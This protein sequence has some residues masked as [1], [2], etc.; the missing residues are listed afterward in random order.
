MSRV[1]SS[2]RSRF[3]RVAAA[4]R[5][6]II[7]LTALLLVAMVGM[8]AFAVDIGYINLTRVEL[9]TCVDAAALAGAY[10]LVDGQAAAQSSAQDF[11]SRNKVRNRTLTLAN[12]TIETGNW[13][14]SS[15]QF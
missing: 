6:N 11:L 8:V 12:A 2:Y 15:R 5:G 1:A 9:Q 7:V 3:G 10:E 4:R 13:N 14:M